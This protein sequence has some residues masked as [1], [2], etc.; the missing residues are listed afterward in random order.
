MAS[1]LKLDQSTL[2]NMTAALEHV[3]RKFPPGADPT[4]RKKIADAISAAAHNGKTTLTAL[5]DVGLEVLH[6]AHPPKRSWLSRLF[7]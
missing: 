6:K 5:Q 7:R 4:L 1:M 2:A 3:Y